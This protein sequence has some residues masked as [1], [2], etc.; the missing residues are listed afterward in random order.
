MVLV[1]GGTGLVGSHL[2]L[3][4]LL[5]NI[6]VRAIYRKGSNLKRVEKVFSYYTENAHELLMTPTNVDP[7]C[8][9]YHNLAPQ[10]GFST[11]ILA[12]YSLG[13]IKTGLVV[14]A[15]AGGL[16]C[17]E[18]GLRDAPQFYFRQ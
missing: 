12:Q 16:M 14:M 9:S 11:Y 10:C 13:L 6:P 2:L 5:N 3:D 17:Y 4:L 8:F 18:K 1:T 7:N 15:A